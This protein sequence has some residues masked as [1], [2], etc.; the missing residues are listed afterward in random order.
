MAATV[1][2]SFADLLT[3]R[4]AGNRCTKPTR[5]NNGKRHC[6][7]MIMVRSLGV[8]GKGG[9]NIIPLAGRTLRI[10]SYRLT[11]TPTSASR[12][13]GTARTTTFRIVK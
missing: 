2:L 9:T 11:A 13:T 10:G 4:M 8:R 1:R 7:R 5:A 3:G 12:G 6:T